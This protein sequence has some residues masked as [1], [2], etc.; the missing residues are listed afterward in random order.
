MHEGN[1]HFI[2]TLAG[3]SNSWSGVNLTALQRVWV[4]GWVCVLSAGEWFEAA[5]AARLTLPTMKWYHVVVW[6]HTRSLRS[7]S[8]ATV[9]EQG[10]KS[11]SLHV[12]CIWAK[13]DLVFLGSIQLHLMNFNMFYVFQVHLTVFNP[14]SLYF[15]FILCTLI[16]LSSVNYNTELLKFSFYNIKHFLTLFYSQIITASG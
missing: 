14:I 8:C 13:P 2:H 11:P 9:L 15:Y 10:T 1:L 4:R 12:W 6:Q 3:H 16:S 5:A 7:T